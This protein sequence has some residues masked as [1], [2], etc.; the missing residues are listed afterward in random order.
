VGEATTGPV[1]GG[2]LRR[3][4]GVWQATALNVTMIVGAGVFISVP[5]M[6]KELPGPWALL[7]WLVAGTLILVDGLVWSELGAALP[8][9]GGSYL[10]LLESYGRD[11]WGR[12]MAFLFIWQFLL[13]GPLEL[14]SGLIAMDMFSQSLSPAWAAFN[15]AHKTTVTIW[16]DEGLALTLSPARAACVV[17]GLA[18]ILLLY[19]SVTTLGR[20]TFLL[21]LGV[22]GII[23]WVLV[24]G[25]RSFDPAVAF[26]FSGAAARPAN[27]L[28]GLGAAMTL[29]LYSYLGYYNICY[30]GDE[31]RDPGKTI[32]RAI[33]LSA[34]L[35]VVLFVLVHLALLGTLSWRD[36]PTSQE[37]LDAYSL[38]AEFMRKLHGEPA[39][40]LITLGLIGTCFA[41][42]F[43]G[44]LGYSRIPYGAARAGHFFAPVAAVHP[45]L[46]IPHVSLLLVGGMTILWSFFDLQSVIT[47]LIT[48]RILEQFV[49]QIV[50]VMIL[51]RTRPDLPRPFRI[52]LYPLP[53]LLALAGWL[54]VYLT[55]KPLYIALGLGTLLAGAVVFFVWTRGRTPNADTLLSPALAD[56]QSPPSS[57]RLRKPGRS[58]RG[59]DHDGGGM[60]R[61]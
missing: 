7:G 52:W 25:F 59:G 11:R 27:F 10:Y 4:F 3:H 8:G 13:S 29:A 12:L 24:E 2:E 19:R 22:L 44:M 35:V 38:P 47:A 43:A 58:E 32:P 53:C 54:F 17:V 45:R 48:T 21:W 41:S 15:E 23:A 28:T 51:R 60:A 5:L 56:R 20:L 26:D 37:A 42:A 34:L 36:V 57:D 30:V 1:T 14:A 9:S 33:L 6:L 39:V 61:G 49:A 31:V 46:L 40:L 18:L 55:A 50:G 16:K